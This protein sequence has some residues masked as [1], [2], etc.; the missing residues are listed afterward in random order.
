MRW[1]RKSKY[2]ELTQTLQRGA[3]IQQS[4]LIRA[5]AVMRG[6]F[7]PISGRR[8]A[9]WSTYSVDDEA[10]VDRPDGTQTP[11]DP[12]RGAAAGRGGPIESATALESVM[13]TLLFNITDERRGHASCTYCVEVV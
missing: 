7:M 13:G 6:L 1:R 3:T 5:D 2:I 12:R 10:N 11:R 9:R 4:N 8:L